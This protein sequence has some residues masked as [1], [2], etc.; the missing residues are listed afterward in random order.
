MREEVRD[1]S[2]VCLFK[3]E[4]EDKLRVL[5]IGRRVV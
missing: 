4:E 2:L 5:V 3:V 1:L